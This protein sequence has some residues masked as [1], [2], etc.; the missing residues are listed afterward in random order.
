[1]ESIYI[2]TMQDLQNIL[3]K[4][5]TSILAMI[6][7]LSLTNTEEYYSKVKENGRDKT[8]YSQKIVDLL[9][10]N[11]KEKV[12]ANGNSKSLNSSSIIT[13]YE[14]QI[15]DKDLQIEYLKERIDRLEQL[16]AVKE[17]KELAET[18]AKLLD[19]GEEKQGFF[20]RL[21]RH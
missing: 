20:K 14:K 16:L 13:M 7:R 10:N 11:N 1:M 21:F 8:Y 19:N 5:R 17:Q 6:N 4:P 9:K 12:K 2:Y 3:G 18:Q 15:K